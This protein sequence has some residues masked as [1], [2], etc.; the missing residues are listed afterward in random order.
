MGLKHKVQ[1]RGKKEEDRLL[2]GLISGSGRIDVGF[3]EEV[4]TWAESEGGENKVRKI[5]V[6]LEFLRTRGISAEINKR[7][8]RLLL[9]LGFLR[10]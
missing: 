10:K 8:R 1:R 2:V 5:G 3:L 9:S 4:G 6:C 7:G